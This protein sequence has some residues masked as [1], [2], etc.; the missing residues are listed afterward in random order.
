VVDV[1]TSFVVTK[2]DLRIK[3]DVRVEEDDDDP[4]RQSL[5]FDCYGTPLSEP[6]SSQLV[7]ETE[8]WSEYAD[9]VREVVLALLWRHHEDN[10]P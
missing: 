10:T 8:R 5:V 9:A 2:E 1:S 4:E 7:D 3:V 6:T